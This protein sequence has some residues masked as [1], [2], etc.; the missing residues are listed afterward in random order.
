LE[1][2][3]LLIDFGTRKILDRSFFF[4]KILDMC[5]NSEKLEE[6][7]EVWRLIQDRKIS[8]KGG[9]NEESGRRGGERGGKGRTRE[10]REGQ[11][12]WEGYLRKGEGERGWRREGRGGRKEEEGRGGWKEENEMLTNFRIPPSPPLPAHPRF[13]QTQKISRNVSNLFKNP[14]ED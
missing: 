1:K 13:F 4:K 8:M 6:A 14:V 2:K 5:N 12:D 7:V 3:K 10:E 9:R 11:R